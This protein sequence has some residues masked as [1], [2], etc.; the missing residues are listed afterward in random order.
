VS[1]DRSATYNQTFLPSKLAVGE[2]YAT[3]SQIL[4]CDDL[5]QATLHIPHWR[6]AGSPAAIR[7]R[8]LSLSERDQVQKAGDATAQYCLTWQLACVIPQFNADQANRLASKN[9][10][11]VEQGAR[12][13][14]LL[15][16]LDQE[17]IEDVVT[18]RTD[19]PAAGAAP[20]GEADTDASAAANPDDSARLRRVA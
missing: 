18:R 13:I 6:I 11:A 15:A 5:P 10:I 20:T 7:V 1:D 2:N 17:W 3:V 8:A 14:W 9:P 12:F 16:S 4:E 19:A